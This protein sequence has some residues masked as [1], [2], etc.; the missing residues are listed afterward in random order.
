MLRA[1]P[2]FVD[3]DTTRLSGTISTG[4]PFT[5]TMRGWFFEPLNVPP[6]EIFCP[7]L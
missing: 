3:E 1:I 7:P 6:A 5:R 2:L 4:C